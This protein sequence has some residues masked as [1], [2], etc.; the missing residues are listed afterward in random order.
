MPWMRHARAG[1][2]SRTGREGKTG[3]ASDRAQRYVVEL[4]RDLAQEPGAIVTGAVRVIALPLAATSRCS[5]IASPRL[6]FVSASARGSLPASVWRR[7]AWRAHSIARRPCSLRACGMHSSQWRRLR[8][9]T[10]F[11]HRAQA[12]GMSGAN[13]L[14]L[15][16]SHSM[17]NVPAFGRAAG[18]PPASRIGIRNASKMHFG[19]PRIA[20]RC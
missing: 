3:G 2:V 20:T 16:R 18:R 14:G 11:P 9:S 10:G 12:I 5:T 17:R 15:A 8:F 13:P 4:R 19:R 7:S 1:T 6:R